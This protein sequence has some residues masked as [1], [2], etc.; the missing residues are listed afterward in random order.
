MFLVHGIQFHLSG[1]ANDYFGKG[2]SGGR[3]IVQ[4]NAE[5]P[6]EAEDNVIIG[7]VALFGSTRGEAY[8]R[9][10]AG[11]GFAVRN[12]VPVRWWKALATTA[13]NT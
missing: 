2:L 10:M 5:C 11:E 1:D 12:S 6:F 13:V 7:N 4:P 8:I 3:L 9:G